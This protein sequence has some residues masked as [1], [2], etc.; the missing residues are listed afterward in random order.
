M[1]PYRPWGKIFGTIFIGVIIMGLF[2]WKYLAVLDEAKH[3][4][5]VQ[6]PKVIKPIY[7]MF[8]PKM[9]LILGAAAAL[10]FIWTGL[11]V[12]LKKDD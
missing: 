9:F 6:V 7:D 3:G 1:E 4:P 8:G 11:H 10:L 2:T 5:F 12:L